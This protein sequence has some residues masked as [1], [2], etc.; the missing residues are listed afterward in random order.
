MT[1][2]KGSVA[3]FDG[4]GRGSSCGSV[5]LEHGDSEVW[6]NALDDLGNTIRPPDLHS[7]HFNSPHGVATDAAGSIYVTE[8]L[9][10]GRLVR[11]VPV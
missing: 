5:R 10:G 6:P 1:E 2:L 4:D 8:W 3:V 11:L 9:I 7:G